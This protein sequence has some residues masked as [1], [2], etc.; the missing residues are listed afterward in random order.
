MMGDEVR[1]KSVKFVRSIHKVLSRSG[2][3]SC[4]VEVLRKNLAC[5]HVPG[6]IWPRCRVDAEITD[7]GT[8]AIPFQEV[9]HFRRVRNMEF[10]WRERSGIPGIQQLFRVRLHQELNYGKLLCMPPRLVSLHLE[11]FVRL[12]GK[13]GGRMTKFSEL[14]F[15]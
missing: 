4:C 12:K 15:K 10:P 8:R 14:H 5:M 9:E 6:R 13:P 3:V 11:A 7:G 1:Q 2:R